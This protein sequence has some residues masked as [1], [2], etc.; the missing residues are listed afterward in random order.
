MRYRGGSRCSRQS[1]S[2]TLLIHRSPSTP[3]NQKVFTHFIKV[4]LAKCFTTMKRIWCPE[5]AAVENWQSAHSVERMVKVTSHHDCIWVALELFVNYANDH[6][7]LHKFKFSSRVMEV[8]REGMGPNWKLIS[9]NQIHASM[10]S[11]INVCRS[12]RRD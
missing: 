4:L 7:S 11:N 1:T 3:E 12:F 5:V 9:T 8:A 2:V 6:K 10:G